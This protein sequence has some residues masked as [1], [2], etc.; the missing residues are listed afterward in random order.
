MVQE[1]GGFVGDLVAI[2]AQRR[3]HQLGSLF[4]NLLVPERL[5]GE[6]LRGIGTFGR[7]LLARTQHALQRGQGL[8]GSRGGL[9][10]RIA[11]EET[12]AR[13]GVACR[14]RRV[15]AHED[16]VLIAVESDGAHRLGIPAG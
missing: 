13:P 10:Q 11:G 5:V 4:A 2:S 8:A 15:D 16:R 12:G 6:Q 9:E 3:H 1:V 14:T 7:G